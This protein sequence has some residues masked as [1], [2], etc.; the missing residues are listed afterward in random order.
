MKEARKR[1]PALRLGALA[2]GA[3]GWLGTAAGEHVESCANFTCVEQMHTCNCNAYSNSS[4]Q[5]VGCVWNETYAKYCPFFTR[6]TARYLVGWLKGAKTHG[7]DFDF[8]GMW[9]ERQFTTEFTIM[10]RQELDSAGFRDVRLV[11]TDNGACCNLTT[12]FLA[13]FH[14]SAALRDAVDVIGIHYPKGSTAAAHTTGLPV[15]AAED[16]SGNASWSGAAS[17]ASAF[18]TNWAVGRRTAAVAWSALVAWY[19]TLP[20]YAAGLMVA[21]QPWSGWFEVAPPIWAAAHFTQFTSIGDILLPAGSGSGVLPNQFGAYMGVARGP[22]FEGWSWIGQS[23]DAPVNDA[24]SPLHLRFTLG[25]ELRNSSQ[26]VRVWRSS[27]AAGV[28]FEREQDIVVSDNGTFA[29]LLKPHEILSLT[30]GTNVSEGHGVHPQPP[31]PAPFPCPW[32]ESFDE[33]SSLFTMGRYFQDQMGS[34]EIV[35]AAVGDCSLVQM[36]PT[37]PIEWSHGAETALS[38]IGDPLWTDINASVVVHLPGQHTIASICVRVGATGDGYNDG[39]APPGYCLSVSSST[40]TV[41]E[42]QKTVASGSL[43]VAV[44]THRLSLEASGTSLTAD[45]DGVRVANFSSTRYHRGQVA[46]G[47]SFAAVSFDDF[48]VFSAPPRTRVE[49]MDNIAT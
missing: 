36:A 10:L 8:I 31:A 3:P 23:M 5:P 38:V 45:V 29:V 33:P 9:N 4:G 42:G 6:D 37:R 20:H 2:W 18:T 17:L 41:V 32:K 48:A 34:F 1:N 14:A 25:A 40:W 26:R 46:I 35:C 15:W 39:Q 19:P 44:K 43:A 21:N 28:L 13:D 27:R 11:A 7:L 16:W 47:C 30:A 24:T 12:R 49:A 22:S